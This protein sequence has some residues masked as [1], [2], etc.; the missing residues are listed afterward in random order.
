MP[1]YQTAVNTDCRSPT[2]PLVMRDYNLMQVSKC[3]STVI[4][5]AEDSHGIIIFILLYS[6]N[7]LLQQK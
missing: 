5:H 1:K 2:C 6:H 3:T 7:R 4:K